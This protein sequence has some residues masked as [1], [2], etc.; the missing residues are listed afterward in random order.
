M[1]TDEQIAEALIKVNTGNAAE[2][3]M[4]AASISTH[5]CEQAERIKELEA[6]VLRL[7]DFTEHS[8]GCTHREHP[9]IQSCT[10]GLE[11]ALKETA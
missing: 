2:V 4:A 5:V 10:C 7:Q 1:L 8:E 6:Q 11:S 3:V 9:F